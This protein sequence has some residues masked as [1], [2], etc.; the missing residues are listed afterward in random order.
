ME[1]VRPK[2]LIASPTYEGKDYAIKDYLDCVERVLSNTPGAESIVIDNSEKGGYK[3]SLVKRY[4]KDYKTKFFH[5]A[6]RGN[7]RNALSDSMNFARHYAIAGDFDYLL[8]IEIDLRPLPDVFWKLYEHQKPVVGALY[9]LGFEGDPKTPKTPC[10]F[11]FDK[12]TEVD[13]GGTRIITPKEAHEWVRTGLRQVHGMG[14][15]CTLLSRS[16]VDR[17]P[18][19]TSERFG[20]KHHDVYFYMDLWNHNVPVFCDTNIIVDHNNSRWELVA[21]K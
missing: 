17:F 15:G 3:H 2:V 6:R 20:N 9:F 5:V 1:S 8:V 11:I 14:L 21:D 12:K 4:A 18:F 10:L 16:I 19:W 13:L 7:S